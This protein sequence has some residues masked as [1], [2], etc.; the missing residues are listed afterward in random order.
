MLLLIKLSLPTFNGDASVRGNKKLFDIGFL[1]NAGKI[2]LAHIL[3][4]RHNITH[5]H[6]LNI[7]YSKT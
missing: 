7:K 1:V 3:K 2:L 5:I 6:Y 4:F